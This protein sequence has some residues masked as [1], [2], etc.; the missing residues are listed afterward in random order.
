[1][2]IVTQ[3]HQGLIVPEHD[4]D[5]II[6]CSPLD[7]EIPSQGYTVQMCATE[8]RSLAHYYLPS[9][10][11]PPTKFVPQSKWKYDFWYMGSTDTHDFRKAFLARIVEFLESNKIKNFVYVY[12][13]YFPT[14]E[15][16]KKEFLHQK[17]ESSL[18]QSKFALCPRGNGIQT[19][20]FYEAIAANILPIYIGPKEA[21]FPLDWI[22]NWEKACFRIDQ[23]DFIRSFKRDRKGS[24]QNEF[25]QSIMS[26]SN[27][28]VNGRR[29]YLF[30]MFCT[31]LHDRKKILKAV[32]EHLEKE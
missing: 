8:P 4:K 5:T 17:F 28:E 1:M 14:L 24:V 27:D 10:V 26:L 13:G 18:I 30:D 11:T 6:E 16:R 20:R 22:I 3:E 31:Y 9:A 15:Q 21:K 25:L 2:N 23:K 12:D 32:K 19:S 7:L 29:K